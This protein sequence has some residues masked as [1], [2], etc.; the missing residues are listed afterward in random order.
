L[1]V[2]LNSLWR[3]AILFGI[4]FF[5]DCF[6]GA[7]PLLNVNVGGLKVDSV[8]IEAGVDGAEVVVGCAPDAEGGAAAAPVFEAF[9]AGEQREEKEDVRVCPENK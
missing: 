2:D 9:E 5:S 3:S 4:F 8:G 1:V 6:G 7:A